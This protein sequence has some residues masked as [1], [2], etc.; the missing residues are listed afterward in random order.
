MLHHAM[1][2]REGAQASMHG[3]PR[4]Q[5]RMPPHMYP[6]QPWREAGAVA[7]KVEQRKRSKYTL[8]ESRYHFMPFALETSGVL[9]RWTSLKS[10]HG[11]RPLSKPAKLMEMNAVNTDNHATLP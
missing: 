5:T 10:L 11:Q 6:K 3:M 8:L 1:E 7:F 9:G 2:I 4:A